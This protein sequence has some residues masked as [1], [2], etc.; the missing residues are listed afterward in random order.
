MKRI[1]KVHFTLPN[2]PK[3]LNQIFLALGDEYTVEDVADNYFSTFDEDYAPGDFFHVISTTNDNIGQITFTPIAIEPALGDAYLALIDDSK[4][5]K[6]LL[7]V[8]DFMR[9]FEKD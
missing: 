2:A 4:T 3:E 8:E 1:L 9:I 5:D 6:T 7:S